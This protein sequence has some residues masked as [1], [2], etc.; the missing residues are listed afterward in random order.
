MGDRVQG[1]RQGRRPFRGAAEADNGLDALLML[2]SP[3]IRS[4][5]S[6][7]AHSRTSG[8][9]AGTTV[10]WTASTLLLAV[11]ADSRLP[12]MAVRAVREQ[13]AEAVPLKT[14]ARLEAILEQTGEQWL[15][16]CQGGQAV[17]DIPW[18]LYTAQ[19]TS[20]HPAAPA[21]ISHRHD[22]CDVAAVPLQT[23]EQGGQPRSASDGDDVLKR[24]SRR[25]ASRASTSKV[26][27][28]GASAF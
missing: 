13:I 27:L 9:V 21:V 16:P 18:R 3:S 17:A 12:V 23:A 5:F 22:G 24:F 15:F 4:P 6:S 20:E 25:C 19:L 11:M 28:S 26:S 2:D 1:A 14:A 8:F 10:P 7:S